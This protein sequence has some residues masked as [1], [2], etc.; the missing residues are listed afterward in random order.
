MENNNH[1]NN[2]QKAFY[3]SIF[4]VG[5]GAIATLD[6]L[7]HSNATV[8]EI[9]AFAGSAYETYRAFAGQAYNG[10]GHAVATV[11]LVPAIAINFFVEGAYIPAMMEAVPAV[12]Y[13]LIVLSHS[14]LDKMIRS[15]DHIRYYILGQTCAKDAVDAKERKR[16]LSNVS[17]SL[18]YETIM[19]AL[20]YAGDDDITLSASEYLLEQIGTLNQEYEVLANT[21]FEDRVE[22]ELLAMEGRESDSKRLEELAN[23]GRKEGDIR[24]SQRNYFRSL[25]KVLNESGPR[26][27]AE[28][29]LT[30]DKVP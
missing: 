5:L 28:K 7:I 8:P 10:K 27:L 1:S 15:P 25:L 29:L 2:I 12:A 3:S 13:P 16:T 22:E 24:I 9:I 4:T 6:G 18:N 23:E 30:P 26:V 21:E 17:R 20:Q 14:N 19:E 11:A